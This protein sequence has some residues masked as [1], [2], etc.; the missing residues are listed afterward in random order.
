MTVEEVE[1]VFFRGV[2]PD[3]LAM[4]CRWPHR[5]PWV[6]SNTHYSQWV[7]KGEG[8]GGDEVRSEGLDVEELRGGITMN[9]IE[10]NYVLWNSQKINR[11]IIIFLKKFSFE[12]FM[13]AF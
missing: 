10:M 7:I 4:L 2:T 5:R 3:R 13:S 11:N 12:G 6:Y 8:K 1:S 9:M